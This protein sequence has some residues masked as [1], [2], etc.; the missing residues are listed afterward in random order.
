MIVR[1]LRD[2]AV[3]G[4]TGTSLM[5]L[6]LPSKSKFWVVQAGMGG[7]LERL[8]SPN[9]SWLARC[10]AYRKSH[11]LAAEHGVRYERPVVA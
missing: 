10:R 8:E 9:A 5:D 2:S 11:E 1:L 4:L 7:S 3:S 6:L